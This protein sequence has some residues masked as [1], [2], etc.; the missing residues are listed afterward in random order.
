M[1][2]IRIV[3]FFQAWEGFANVETECRKYIF[4][5]GTGVCTYLLKALVT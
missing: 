2:L 4:P 1:A 5:G 3:S